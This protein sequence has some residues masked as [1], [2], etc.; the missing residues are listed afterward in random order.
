[1]LEEFRLLKKYGFELLEYGTC[2]N[3][4]SCIKTAKKIGY[5]VALK[6]LSAQASHKTEVGGV[7]IGIT[8]EDG[9]KVAYRDI[10]LSAKKHNVKIDSILVQKMARKGV[11]LIIGGKKDQ[12]FGHMIILGLGGIYVEIFRD[13][14]AR[15]CPIQEKDI[16]EMIEELRSHP[17]ITGAR[18]RKP[19]SIMKLKK[20][21]LAASKFMVA[22][23]LLEIDLNPVIC[24]E[25]GCDLVDIRFKSGKNEK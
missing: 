20:L 10:L 22:E 13:I 21:M 4:D 17:L 7:K 19:I 1:M 15:I 18:G 16:D 3:I 11:E 12:Q 5:P 25:N 14:S 8:G 24:D 6:L 23:D 2:N 9:L